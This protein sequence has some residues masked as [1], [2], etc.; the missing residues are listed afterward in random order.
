MVLP[1]LGMDY[2]NTRKR[3]KTAE[4]EASELKGQVKGQ[5]NELS[6]ANQANQTDTDA[7][8]RLFG[9]QPNPSKGFGGNT[10]TA[11]QF[12]LSA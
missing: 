6:A 12:L 2:M 11:R 3:A 9:V 8:K 4:A 10:N 1:L 5:V 7:R